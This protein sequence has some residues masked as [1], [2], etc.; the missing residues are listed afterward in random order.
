MKPARTRVVAWAAAASIMCVA[1]GGRIAAAGGPSQPPA[2]TPGAGAPAAVLLGIGIEAY[3]G[4]VRVSEVLHLENSSTR[5]FSGDVTIPIPASAGFLTYHEG[6][7]NPRVESDRIVDR[8][9]IGPGAHRVVYAYS[10][11]G[12]GTVNLDRPATMLIERVDVLALAPAGIRSDRLTAAP[13]VSLRGR[14]Y[15]RAS[16]AVAA[17]GTFTLSVTGVPA[18]RRWPAPA[19]AAT[20]GA[21][22]LIGLAVAMVRGGVGGT[23]W[24]RFQRSR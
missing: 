19:A 24:K 13:S 5:V 20:L 11:V 3:P 1:A 21:I 10:V 12:S 17:P 16:G 8:M 9:T 14:T 15:L 4:Y 7:F 23:S 2:G 6:L 22:L 18:L